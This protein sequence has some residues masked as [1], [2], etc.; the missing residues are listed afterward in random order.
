MATLVEQLEL[1]ARDRALTRQKQR[2]WYLVGIGPV[3]GNLLPTCK[4][5]GVFRLTKTTPLADRI[6][7]CSPRS[8]E[9]APVILEG[10]AKI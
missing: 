7:Y 10:L 4:I 8:R 3:G 1:F 5:V 6:N 2:P 9:L